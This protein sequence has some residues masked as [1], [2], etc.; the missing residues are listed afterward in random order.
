MHLSEIR[1]QGSGE[2]EEMHTLGTHRLKTPCIYSWLFDW[3]PQRRSRWLVLHCPGCCVQS[4]LLPPP[5][6]PS[7]RQLAKRSQWSPSPR[8]GLGWGRQPSL[9]HCHVLPHSA[10]AWGLVWRECEGLAACLMV[11]LP[12]RTISAPELPGG[13]SEAFVRPPGSPAALPTPDSFILRSFHPRGPS[14]Y[15]SLACVPGS[16]DCSMHI[17]VIIWGKY[18]SAVV[19]CF[20]LHKINWLITHIRTFCASQGV[21]WESEEIYSVGT[22]LLFGMMYQDPLEVEPEY[23]VWSDWT[24]SLLI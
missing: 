9:N 14:R 11:R 19:C 20:E 13:S 3:E 18:N 2:K 5:L 1:S 6:R 16:P 24:R 15:M 10:W 22:K 7:E 4:P 8:T 17:C 12:W 23:T 21:W